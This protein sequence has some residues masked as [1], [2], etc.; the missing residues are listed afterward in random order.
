[1]GFCIFNF[2]VGAAVYALEDLGLSRVGIID[3]DVHYGNGVADLVADNPKIRYHQY[4]LPLL[5]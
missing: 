4:A 2:A 1:M 3:F 5:T